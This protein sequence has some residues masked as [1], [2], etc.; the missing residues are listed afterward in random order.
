M[1]AGGAGVIAERVLRLR[2]SRSTRATCR[3]SGNRYRTRL[4]I[5]QAENLQPNDVEGHFRNLG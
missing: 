2:G 1:Y 4:V 3:P 5:V